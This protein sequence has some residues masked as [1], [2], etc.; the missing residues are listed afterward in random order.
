MGLLWSR[1]WEKTI[2]TGSEKVKTWSSQ[3]RQW[4]Y[5]LNRVLVSVLVIV[6]KI[7]NNLNAT[8]SLS[9]FDE[10]LMTVE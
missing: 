5:G 9:N 1:I 6:E 10:G 7:S 3:S 8:Q 2:S 4:G